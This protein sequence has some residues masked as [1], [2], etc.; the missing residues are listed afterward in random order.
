[1]G[2]IGRGLV[3]F[4][5]IGQGDTIEDARYL[6]EKIVHLRVFPDEEGRFDRSVVEVGGEVLV[7][8]Q[9][10]LYAETRKGRRPSFPGAAPPS[11]ALPLYEEAV[12][13]LRHTGV[14][15]ATGRFQEHMVVEVVNDGPVSILIDSADRHRPR[16]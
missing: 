3:V 8:S 12:A 1:M 2:R 5:G 16:G 15:V 4:L 11:E 6:V 14:P 13:L 10:T 9:F 7:V